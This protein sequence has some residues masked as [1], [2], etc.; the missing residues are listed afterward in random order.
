MKENEPGKIETKNEDVDRAAEEINHLEQ[1]L[2]LLQ[3]V[4]QEHTKANK[5]V[6][7]W[8]V[9]LVEKTFRLRNKYSNYKEP[10]RALNDFIDRLGFM[11]LFFNEAI[12]ADF[13]KLVRRRV[14]KMFAEDQEPFQKAIKRKSVLSALRGK[15]RKK[16]KLRT[17]KPPKLKP[18]ERRKI[19]QEPKIFHQEELKRQ[20][21]RTKKEAEHVFG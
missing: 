11:E 2:L 17:K 7:L 18:A 9:S 3:K 1:D 20:L 13:T 4:L 14:A 5:G 6:Y 8:F 21:K 12:G 19:R 15:K 10:Q 16:K